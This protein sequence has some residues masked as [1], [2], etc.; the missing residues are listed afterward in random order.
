VP[1]G[2][3]SYCRKFGGKVREEVITVHLL[4]KVNLGAPVIKYKDE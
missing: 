2:V 1:E 4:L 3:S